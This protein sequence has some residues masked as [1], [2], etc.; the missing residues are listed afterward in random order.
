MKEFWSEN[1]KIIG[2]LIL[3]QFGSAFLG[4]MLLFSAS[5]VTSQK[6]WLVLIASII[7][8]I[9][10][11]YLL[12]NL[13]WER[14]GQDRIKIDGGRASKKPLTGLLISLFANIPNIVIALVILVTS[15]FKTVE[16]AGNTNL[17]FRTFSFLW[18]GMYAGIVSYFAPRNPI[19]HILIVLPAIFVCTGAY[20]LGLS[21]FRL[22]GGPVVNK[23]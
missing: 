8:T 23:K 19:M 9:F 16:F 2:K 4:L 5:A 1:S 10:Y 11:L 14:G 3:N 22:L 20:L 6:T 18:E 17:L 7:T 12:Y 21:N 15:F 13:L